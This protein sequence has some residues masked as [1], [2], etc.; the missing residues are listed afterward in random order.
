M[1]FSSDL[2]EYSEACSSHRG[3]DRAATASERE[4]GSDRATEMMGKVTPFILRRTADL[5]NKLLPPCTALVVFC[6][7]SDWQVMLRLKTVRWRP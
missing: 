7:P 5:M 2:N 1:V 4:L 3:R 6:R